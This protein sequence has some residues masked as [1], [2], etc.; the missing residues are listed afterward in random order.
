[1]SNNPYLQRALAHD[2][3]P[4]PDDWPR[5][6]DRFEARGIE[7]REIVP[8]INVLSYKGWLAVGRYVRRGEVGVRL[9]LRPH[10][11]K[12]RRTVTLFHIS[13]T[14]ERKPRE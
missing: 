9:S 10:G 1:M 8:H 2:Q 14:E 7:R 5:I 3:T 4:C 13:Q 12:K 6:I 11:W